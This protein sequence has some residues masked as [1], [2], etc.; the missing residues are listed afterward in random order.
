MIR[1]PLFLVRSITTEVMLVKI[2]KALYRLR[3]VRFQWIRQAGFGY[4]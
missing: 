4:E 3:T 1:Q 2:K